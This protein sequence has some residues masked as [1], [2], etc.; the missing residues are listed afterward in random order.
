MRR[1]ICIIGMAALSGCATPQTGETI[2]TRGPMPTAAQAE[3]AIRQYLA[4]NLKDPDSL[5]QFQVTSAPREMSW[6]RGLIN[7]GGNDQAWLVCYEYSAKNSY[8][9]YGGLVRDGA[10]IR[11]QGDRPY[12]VPQVNWTISNA[13]C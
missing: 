10:A 8:G 13:G 6:Y 2:S 7:G 11:W 12:V 1:I 3:S 4:Q 5:K 9:A